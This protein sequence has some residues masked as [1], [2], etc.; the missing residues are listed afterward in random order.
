MRTE[1]QISY[2]GLLGHSLDFLAVSF[3]RLEIYPCVN[4]L[5]SEGLSYPYDD[6]H[7][8]LRQPF[9]LFL[10]PLPRCF[11]SKTHC[12][13]YF[14]QH[15]PCCLLRDFY[16]ICELVGRKTYFVIGNKPN[17][18]KPFTQTYLCLFKHRTCANGKVL[19]C[20]LQR[21]LPLFSL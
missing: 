5:A 21:Y 13:T 2:Q 11:I 20:I 10:L 9:H 17:S 8:Y 15:I 14:M 18:D 7:F 19:T 3:P 4:V 12:M 6:S 1:C 16:I